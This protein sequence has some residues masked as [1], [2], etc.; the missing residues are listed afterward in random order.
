MNKMRVIMKP[1]ARRNLRKEERRVENKA[2]NAYRDRPEEEEED[3]AV[4]ALEVVAVRQLDGR[5]TMPK[6]KHRRS[7]L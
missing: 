7:R 6:M 5:R 1:A 4:A 2:P 3:E